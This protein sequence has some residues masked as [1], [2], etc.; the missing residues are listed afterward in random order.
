MLQDGV[1]TS[2]DFEAAKI[3]NDFLPAQIFDSHAHLYDTSFVPG[4]ANNPSM[5][6]RY[7]LTQYRQDMVPIFGQE[8]E[9]HLNIVTY[10]DRAMADPAH[11]SRDLA[12]AFLV[13]QL[14]EDPGSVGEIITVPGD[15]A[16]SLSKRLVHPRIRGF[17]C[18]HYCSGLAN[19]WNAS[20]GQYLPEAAWQVAHEKKLVITLHMVK[21]HAL[22]D[23]DNLIYITTMA[24]AYPDATLILAHAAR[25]FAAWTGIEAV[26]KVAHLDNVWF[27]LSAVCESPAMLQIFKKTGTQRSMWGSDYPVSRYCGKA[28]SLGD[29]FYWIYKKDLENF[30]GATS[31]SSYLVGVE[32]LLATR[33]ACILMDLDQKAI[34]D[35]FY[36]NAARLFGGK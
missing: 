18:Y 30:S 28:I 32:N 29:S 9:L 7:D 25:S 11:P 24:K 14:E 26:E 27:D 2:K 31:F 33:Q 15:T 8:R 23:P 20:I 36:G 13:Q 16:E 5:A 22:A 17:K 34:E 1:Y 19:S 6:G 12:D 35:I 4:L 10:P 21:D 3:L